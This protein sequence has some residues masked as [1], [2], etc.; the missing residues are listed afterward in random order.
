MDNVQS[1]NLS[2]VHLHQEHF[3]AVIYEYFHLSQ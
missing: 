1:E 2:M 3:E